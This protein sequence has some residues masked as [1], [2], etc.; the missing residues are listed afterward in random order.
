[1]KPRTRIAVTR[2]GLGGV[3]LLA[4]P[5]AVSAAD[6]QVTW[7]N[8]GKA[9]FV[10]TDFGFALSKDADQTGACPDGWT[11]G[12]REVY[13]STPE[14]RRRDGE[15]DQDYARRIALGSQ[16][17]A[18]APNGQNLCMNPEAGKPDPHWRIVSKPDVP[19]Y[20]I[21]LDGQDSRA[22]GRPA[23][24][25]CAHDDFRGFNGEKGIDNQ[26][27]RVVGCSRSYQS[28]GQSAD[29]TI[30]LRTGSW[31][32]LIT[33]AGVDDIRNDPSVEV[34]IYAS[35]DPIQLS[36]TRE[37]VD[38]ATYATMQDPRFR[39]TTHGRIVNGVLTTDPVDVRFYKV[40]NSMY[41][42]RP[43]RDARLQL[44]IAPDG[45]LEGYL[46]GY[47]PVE[48]IYD[49]QY[50]YR[51][52]TDGKGQPSPLRLRSISANG[53]AAVNNH[54]C[55]GAYWA[56]RAQADG[57]PDKNG[58]CTTISTQYRIRAIPAFV[59][60]TATKSANVGLDAKSQY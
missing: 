17:L 12:N 16:A 50:G 1:M 31:G 22:K 42:E 30:E 35:A 7:V 51:S 47:A 25:T 5:G 37:P 3:A 26:F 45:K 27:F 33:L 23:P 54:T 60:D 48:A 9:G 10:V 21:D 49:H 13:Q 4:L 19:A 46:A 6:S 24:N 34:G 40:T 55:Q 32:V 11:L 20:G 44:T 52:A 57:H 39:A 58:Q 8:R 15:A 56:L 14:G 36:P 41:L 43:L 29:N 28:T 38:F 53:N 59:V 2:L 18:T